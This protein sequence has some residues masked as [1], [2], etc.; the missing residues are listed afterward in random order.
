MNSI[1]FDNAKNLKHGER[2]Q[3]QVTDGLLATGTITGLHLHQ[4]FGTEN[5]ANINMGYAQIFSATNRYY[6]KPLVGM[7]EAKGKI[8]IIDRSGFRWEL[9]GGNAQK[10]RITNKVNTDPKPG[11][12]NMSQNAGG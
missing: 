10:A 6:G 11:L 9:S 1:T 4:T 12:Y 8:K 2:K 3:T 7:T 5:L